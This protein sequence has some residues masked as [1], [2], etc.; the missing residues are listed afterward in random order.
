[1]LHPITY[2]YNHI[3]VNKTHTEGSFTLFKILKLLIV[4][5]DWDLTHLSSVSDESTHF[6]H[7]QLTSNWYKFDTIEWPVSVRVLVIRLDDIVSATQI[8]PRSVRKE[9]YI[10][11]LTYKREWSS[12]T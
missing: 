6:I 7:K 2:D 8:E 5:E 4:Y 11:M 1:M 9:F 3:Y 12:Y 10:N